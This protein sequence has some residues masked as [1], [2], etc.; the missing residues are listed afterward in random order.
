MRS[1]LARAALVVSLLACLGVL[2]AA[3]TPCGGVEG[4]TV[5][6]APPVAAVGQ[7]VLVTIANDSNETIYLPSSCVFGAFY[8]GFGCT[9]PRVFTPLCLAVI[10]PLPPGSSETSYWL[11]TDDFNQQVKSGDYSVNATYWD[12]GFENLHTCCASFSISGNC[13]PA[14][15][16]V[17]AGSG[18]NTVKLTGFGAPQLGL[19][20][21]T[22]LDCSGHAPGL[23]GLYV[24]EQPSA[25]V[26]TPF[27]ELLVGGRRYARFLQGH[28]S[29]AAVFSTA[30]PTDVSLCGLPAS[31]QGACFGSPGP[32]LSNALDVVLGI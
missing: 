17:R 16:T 25:G 28:T 32:R 8:S 10:T 21:I 12:S 4:V 31:V 15:S 23:A 6:V 18:V 3:Q 19:P 24:F 5:S 30:V 14:G 1:K 11:Q 2:P 26:P 13:A 27:G 9:G 7:P 29:S 20:W 22:S